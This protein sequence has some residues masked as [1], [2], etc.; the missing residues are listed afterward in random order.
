LSGARAAA[1]AANA[2]GRSGSGVIRRVVPDVVGAAAVEQSE[3]EHGRHR[4]EASSM[5]RLADV[6]GFLAFL[7]TARTAHKNYH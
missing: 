7:R 4:H 3:P 2:T 1:G 6:H 5:S